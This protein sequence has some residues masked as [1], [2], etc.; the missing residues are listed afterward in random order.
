MGIKFVF[1]WRFNFFVMNRKIA[2]RVSLI[3][4]VL[5]ER[6]AVAGV[7][8]CRKAKGL[9]IEGECLVIQRNF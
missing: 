7:I 5:D 3:W 2:R 4:V 9:F 8:V 1:L 6:L